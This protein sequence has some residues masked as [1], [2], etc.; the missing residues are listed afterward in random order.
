MDRCDECG[1][2]YYGF[3]RA[4][5]APRLRGLAADV[6]ERLSE[7]PYAY[8]SARPV[9]GWSA[10][11][12]GCHVRDVL[13]HQ[14]ARIQRAQVE[15]QPEFEPMG[16]DQLAVD[17]RYNDQ[18][19]DRVA[20]EVIAAADGLA[21]LLESLDDAGWA[22]TG[23]YGYPTRE[24]RQVDWIGRHTVHELTHHLGDVDRVLRSVLED[25]G[26]GRFTDP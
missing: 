22:R 2:D 26:G 15:D 7:T 19:P 4:D 25:G 8:A 18:H 13:V 9:E 24:V 10:L 11:E 17:Q 5:I 20:G 21:G 16:R 6:A 14:Q 3:T 12:Y 23:V 1:F